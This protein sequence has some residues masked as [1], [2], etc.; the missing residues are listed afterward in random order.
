MQRPHQFTIY[1]QEGNSSNKI[2]G[3]ML[4]D[5]NDKRFKKIE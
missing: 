3:N 4:T 2:D 5:D 1:D